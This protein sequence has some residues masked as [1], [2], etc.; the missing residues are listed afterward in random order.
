M[1]NCR[2]HAKTTMAERPFGADVFRLRLHSAGLEDAIQGF[3]RQ[4]G[5]IVFN[6][7]SHPRTVFRLA[8]ALPKR[9]VNSADR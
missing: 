7:Q 6:V 5:T 4:P 8:A 1:L 2:R 9:D 3:I